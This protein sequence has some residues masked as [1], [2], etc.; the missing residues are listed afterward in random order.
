MEI[1]GEPITDSLHIQHMR[2]HKKN[3]KACVSN[4]VELEI[5]SICGEGFELE[6]AGP[7]FSV[8]TNVP[9]GNMQ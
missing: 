6:P 5:M 9:L 4:M 7:Y 8:P 2:K 3:E 1:E